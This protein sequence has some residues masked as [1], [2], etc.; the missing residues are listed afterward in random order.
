MKVS[1]LTFAN[2]GCSTLRVGSFWSLLAFG[3]F[4]F[5]GVNSFVFRSS[6]IVMVDGKVCGFGS[7]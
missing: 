7:E 2:G 1:N 6:D 4:L 3:R 5:D